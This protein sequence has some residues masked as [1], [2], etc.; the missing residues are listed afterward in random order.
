M[1]HRCANGDKLG[2]AI[3]E[4]LKAS[5]PEHLSILGNQLV[6]LI[7]DFADLQLDERFA[8]L[9]SVMRE[10]KRLFADGYLLVGL[11]LQLVNVI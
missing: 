9:N 1:P 2:I 7:L 5:R 3:R 10:E 4:I 6:Y 8:L 11:F